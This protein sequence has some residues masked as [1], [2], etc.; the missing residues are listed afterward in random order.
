M[1]FKTTS[2]NI[3]TRD[4]K[5]QNKKHC[6]SKQTVAQ[7]QGCVWSCLPQTRMFIVSRGQ[8]WLRLMAPCTPTDL[9]L[10]CIPSHQHSRWPILGLSWHLKATSPKTSGRYSGIHPRDAVH[11][12]GNA[13]G[14]VCSLFLTTV[15]PQPQ[16]SSLCVCTKL[17]ALRPRFKTSNK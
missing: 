6:S 8:R 12:T 4:S 14:R 10:K 17:H 15:S 7:I 3:Q 1:S 2:N 11:T 9:Y 16:L 5:L 13:Q